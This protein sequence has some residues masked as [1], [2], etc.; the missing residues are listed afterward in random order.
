[1]PLYLWARYS[2]SPIGSSRT[3]P[4]FVQGPFSAQLQQ[5]VVAGVTLASLRT[6]Y[7]HV[8]Q[9]GLLT[10]LDDSDDLGQPCPSIP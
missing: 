2:Q 1:M 10:T 8:L 7:C 4:V 5:E 6:G 9:P 3:R